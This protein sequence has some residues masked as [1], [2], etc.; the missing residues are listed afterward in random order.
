MT[1]PI[2]EQLW[3]GPFGVAPGPLTPEPASH[4]VE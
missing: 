1:H 4:R 3:F 2:V